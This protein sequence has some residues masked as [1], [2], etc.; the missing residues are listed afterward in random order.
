MDSTEEQELFLPFLDWSD[1]LNQFLRQAKPGQVIVVLNSIQ[2]EIALNRARSQ[3]KEVIIR[4][5][6]T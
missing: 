1:V 6:E 3:N 5:K 2:E 4:L